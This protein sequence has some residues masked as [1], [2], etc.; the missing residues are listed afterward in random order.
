MLTAFIFGADMNKHHQDV[1][2]AAGINKTFEV[3]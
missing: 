3:S 1:M 2:K